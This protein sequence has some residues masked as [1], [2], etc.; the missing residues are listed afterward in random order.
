MIDL[1]TIY[2]R[3]QMLSTFPAGQQLA[4]SYLQ[5]IQKGLPEGAQ[6]KSDGSIQA[7]TGYSKFVTDKAMAEKGFVPGPNGTYAPASG[8]PADL[9]YIGSAEAAK[10]WGGYGPKLALE[11]NKPYALRGP[12]ASL[13]QGGRVVAQ[14]PYQVESVDAQGHPYTSFILPPVGG[15]G[16]LISGATVPNG[17]PRASSVAGGGAPSANPTA[18]NPSSAAPAG[19]PNITVGANGMPVIQKGLSPLEHSSAE[20]RGT[21]LEAFGEQLDKDAESA[22]QNNFLLD[23]MRRESQTWQLGKFADV[24][25]NALAYLQ[26]FANTFSIPTTGLDQ[27][28]GDFQSFNKSGVELVRQ[29]VRQTSA[30]AAYQ[31]FQIIAGALPNAEMSPKAFSQIAD[32]MQGVNDYRIAMQ[33]AAQ[34]W[35]GTHNGTLDG[36]QQAWNQSI[37]PAAFLVHRMSGE[38]LTTMTANLQKTAEGRAT[39]ANLQREIATAQQLG[40][41]NDAQ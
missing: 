20:A 8:G 1:P 13:I 39:I 25:N 36:F 35:R 2:R 32:Q 4:T 38:D 41:F 34:T 40:L 26:G 19:G 3:A 7:R 11:T 28:V 22:Q 6:L 5:M 12:G 33:S 14:N 9:G 30:R 31:E 18:A 17:G 21:K 24:K 23:N 10:E 29:A 37:T 27:R 16:G 15:N